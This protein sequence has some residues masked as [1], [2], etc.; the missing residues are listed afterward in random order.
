MKR[1]VALIVVAVPLGFVPGAVGP[2]RAGAADLSVVQKRLRDGS[3]LAWPVRLPAESRSRW[4]PLA[5]HADAAEFPP[6]LGCG[7]VG[8]LATVVGRC[9]A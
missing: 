9:L 7:G 1:V 6:P 2:G 3:P 5:R 4:Q 8:D